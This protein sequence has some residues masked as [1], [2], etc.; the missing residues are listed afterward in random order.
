MSRAGRH[1]PSG[2]PIEIVVLDQEDDPPETIKDGK[3]D[4]HSESPRRLGKKSFEQVLKDGRLRVIN[5]GDPMKV[6][7]EVVS[8]MRARHAAEIGSLKDA[9][10]AEL[11]RAEEAHSELVL[12]HEKLSGSNA[13]LYAAHEDLKAHAAELEAENGKL[14]E[15]LA[16]TAPDTAPEA[17][18]QPGKKGAKKADA[19]K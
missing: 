4:R 1:W 8:N 15:R 17:D 19:A 2:Q 10:E 7:T 16:G 13:E 11:E 3:S 12:A 18:T 9:H 6:E 5:A 14:L